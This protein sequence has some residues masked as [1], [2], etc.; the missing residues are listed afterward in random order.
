MRKKRIIAVCSSASF[1]E[2]VLEI[3]KKLKRLGFKVLV[4]I[5]ARRMKKKGNFDVK[6]H[7][8]WLANKDDYKKKTRLMKGH[9]REIIKSDAVLMVNLPKNGIEGYIGGDGLLEMGL[10][11]HL[12]KPIYILNEIKDDHPFAEEIIGLGSIFLSGDLNKIR[13]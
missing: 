11:F 8:T 5:T 10:A 3:E 13:K 7:K 9:F 4:P 12:K 6:Q 1:Y 2:E